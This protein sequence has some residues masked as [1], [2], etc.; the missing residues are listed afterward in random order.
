LNYEWAE[1]WVRDMKRNAHLAPS[2]IRHRHGALARCFDWMMRKH[3]EIMAQNPLRLLKRGFAT[4]T[5]AD[6][7]ALAAVGKAP[8]IDEERER[9]LA[10]EE[11]A[12]IA[13]D[14]KDRADE[15]LM[16]ELA[17]QTAMRMRE[18]Y[19]LH[20]SQLSLPKRTVFLDRTK[21][22]SSR[23]VPEYTLDGRPIIVLPAPATLDVDNY[24]GRASNCKAQLFL[25]RGPVAIV[26][27]A[28]V[29]RPVSVVSAIA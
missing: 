18:C 8:R 20:S 10:A 17:L 15:K 29:T 19:T 28:R 3:P 9:R 11:E 5:D 22:G 25:D 4:Y 13:A 21:N 16:F 2:T 7:Q 14:L 1:G 27:P 26:L 23:Q 6:A 24:L 12:R